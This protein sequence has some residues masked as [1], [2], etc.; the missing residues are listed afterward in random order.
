[1]REQ[2]PTLAAKFLVARAGFRQK[3]RALVNPARQRAVI[4]PFDR[5]PATVARGHDVDAR[6]VSPASTTALDFR[7]FS[8]PSGGCQ[9]SAPFP[10]SGSEEERQWRSGRET[11]RWRRWRRRFSERRVSARRPGRFRL[12]LGVGLHAGG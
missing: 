8:K 2:R 11:W 12:I 3:R 4:E 7:R 5:R 6:I 10:A 9:F 1:M